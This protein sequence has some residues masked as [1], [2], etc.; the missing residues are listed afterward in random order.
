MA[1]V[2]TDAGINWIA[3]RAHPGTDEVLESI[4]IGT[5]TT[6]PESDDTSLD[7]EIYRGDTSL[8]T[9]SFTRSSTRGQIDASVTI[10]GGTEV[11]P[12]DAITEIGVY[13][14][15]DR[16]VYREVRESLTIDEGERITI[17]FSFVVGR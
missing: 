15:D 12:G 14:S 10:A 4:A 13:T 2:V 17:E 11:D 7:T 16:L 1:Y 8:E 5:G 9:I 3:D 6:F